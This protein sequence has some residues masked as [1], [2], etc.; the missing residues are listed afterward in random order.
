MF[1][2]DVTVVTH[3]KTS[4]AGHELVVITGDGWLAG[5]QNLRDHPYNF[6]DGTS[7]GFHVDFVTKDNTGCLLD[8]YA[9]ERPLQ[10]P[11]L[12]DAIDAG[13]ILWSPVF[14]GRSIAG[15]S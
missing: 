13:N 5:E 1:R 14:D 12:S 11:S 3:L 2:K 15:K 7:E 4:N 9:L 8:S 6:D 10:W